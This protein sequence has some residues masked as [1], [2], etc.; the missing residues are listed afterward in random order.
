MV[1]RRGPEHDAR[2]SFPA[3]KFRSIRTNAMSSLRSRDV[4][5]VLVVQFTDAKILDDTRIQQIGKELLDMTAKAQSGK[6][7]LNFDGVS[8]MS[9]AMIG[10][11]VL[12]N[13]KC[14]TSNI[15]LKLCQI[16]ANVFEVFKIMRLNKVFDIHKDEERAVKAFDKKGWFG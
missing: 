5:D 15:D 9:S 8:F 11:L 3:P 2:S 13:K 16:T 4:E 7:V 10:K 6:M 12:L 14:K 1:W